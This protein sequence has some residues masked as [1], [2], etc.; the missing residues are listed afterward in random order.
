MSFADRR[1]ALLKRSARLRSKLA[2]HSQVFKPAIHAAEKVID[3]AQN[4]RQRPGWMLAGKVAITVIPALFP[5]TRVVRL[6]SRAVKSARALKR[7]QPLAS[8]FYKYMKK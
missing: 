6:A 5:N 4:I 3:V 7:L 1:K 8:E 2:Q